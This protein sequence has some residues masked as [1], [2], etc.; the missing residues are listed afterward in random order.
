MG[1]KYPLRGAWQ[2]TPEFLPGKSCGQGRL[3]G[4]SPWGRRVGPDRGTKNACTQRHGQVS[5]QVCV[6]KGVTSELWSPVILPFVTRL[7]YYLLLHI[8]W[9]PRFSSLKVILFFWIR[10]SSAGTLGSGSLTRLQSRCRPGLRLPQG[11]WGWRIRR[12]RVGKVNS[13]WTQFPPFIMRTIVLHKLNPKQFLGKLSVLTH[14]H[15]EGLWN[16]SW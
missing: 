13:D 14:D 1:G 2:T 12:C 16:V 15:S 9:S 3:A 10:S 4:Y 7:V 11:F 5:G 8:E 6:C